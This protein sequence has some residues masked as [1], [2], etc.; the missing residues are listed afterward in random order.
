MHLYP[1]CGS[2]K[3]YRLFFLIFYSSCVAKLTS[4]PKVIDTG[5]THSIF[6]CTTFH[7]HLRIWWL[8]PKVV[9]LFLFVTVHTKTDTVRCL[10][11]QLE[12]E[13]CYAQNVVFIS[14]GFMLVGALC[15]VSRQ[16]AHL[17][18]LHWSASACH[19]Q[20]LSRCD[21]KLI[22]RDV[23]KWSFKVAKANEIQFA[24][25]TDKNCRFFFICTRA[26]NLTPPWT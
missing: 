22:A 6:C 19:C 5:V 1:I 8:D 11:Q 13:I 24:S 3:T 10:I 23:C 9:A 25:G 7:A 2:S 20:S 14:L 4:V 16:V 26:M 17:L 21:K 18:N 12:Q 15:Q